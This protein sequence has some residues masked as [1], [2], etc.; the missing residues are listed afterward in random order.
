MCAHSKRPKCFPCA[1][2]VRSRGCRSRATYPTLYRSSIPPL[3]TGL[4]GVSTGR[5]GCHAKNQTSNRLRAFPSGYP[6][7]AQTLSLPPERVLRD[8]FVLCPTLL[9][10]LETAFLSTFSQ[11]P[12]SPSPHLS[13]VTLS[14]KAASQEIRF[15]VDCCKQQVKFL[16]QFTASLQHDK[17]IILNRIMSFKGPRRSFLFCSGRRFHVTPKIPSR[18]RPSLCSHSLGVKAQ[19]GPPEVKSRLSQ[20]TRSPFPSLQNEEDDDSTP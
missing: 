12:S 14:E 7:V 6:R 16:Q 1:V 2:L 17:E 3:P 9:P 19:D 11:L 15:T 8:L 18:A 4:H 10:C 20:A 5:L 13:S